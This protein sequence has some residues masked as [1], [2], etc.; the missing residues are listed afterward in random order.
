MD[1]VT[2]DIITTSSSSKAVSAISADIILS[3]LYFDIFNYPLTN[4][5]L[6]RH[7]SIPS[8]TEEA[9]DTAVNEL[10]DQKLIQKAKHFIYI[11]SEKDNVERRILGNRK[12]DEYLKKAYKISKFISHFPFIR[13]IFL[14]G[15]ISKGYADKDSDIDYFILTS[16]GRLWFARTILIV[17][18]KVVLF[19]SKKYFCL[20]YFIDT[21]HLEIPDKN[22]FTAT[23]LNYLIPTY[24]KE[25]YSQL[26]N[27]NSWIKSY[28]PNFIPYDK[29]II[30]VKDGLIKCFLE[31][32]F[33]GFIGD[34]LD[35]L[36]MKTNEKFW[37][38][39]YRKSQGIYSPSIR[40]KK[41][42]SKIHPQNFQNR[43]LDLYEAKIS[44]YEQRYKIKL[45][46]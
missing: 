34:K 31:K 7:S 15:S 33:S 21:E 29:N 9:L 24:N 32:L 40:C 4:K 44:D 38:F 5:E 26:M 19:N 8:L 46:P 11:P 17:V 6:V 45:R 10:Y 27:S 23:E 18:K 1:K 37:K 13:G 20:N 41:H 2:K 42:V 43:V 35:D 3:L 28:Q 12:A 36:F 14:S 16:P 22:V 30:H 39:K 25:I